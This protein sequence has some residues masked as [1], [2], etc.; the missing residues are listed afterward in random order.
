MVQEGMEWTEDSLT[1]SSANSLASVV[2]FSDLQRELDD[3][4]V[5][6]EEKMP[7]QADFKQVHN[8]LGFLDTH[9]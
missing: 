5:S 4:L 9:A 8:M 1:S 2:T 7:R 6:Q 3:E